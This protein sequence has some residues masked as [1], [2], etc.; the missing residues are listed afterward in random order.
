MFT[1]IVE[2]V[3]SV[4]RVEPTGLTVAGPKVTSDLKVS[5]SICV[6]GACLTVTALDGDSFRVDVVPETLRRTTSFPTCQPFMSSLDSIVSMVVQSLA[7]DK[8]SQ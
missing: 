4:A 2:E 5:D 7:V 3:G 1:G 6:N 8:R